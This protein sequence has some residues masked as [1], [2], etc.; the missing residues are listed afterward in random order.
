MSE[1]ERFARH[2]AL[3]EV[4]AGGQARLEASRMLI[5]GLGGLGC[6]AAQYLASSGVGTLMLN[7]FDH[8][9]SS[10]LPRQILFAEADIGRPK[11][12]AAAAA[13]QRLNAEARIEALPARLP[14]EGLFN[15]ASRAD[16]VLDCTDNFTTRLAINRACVTAGKPLV[17]GA[18][19]RFEGQI[20]VFENGGGGPCYRCLYSEED[21]LLGDCAGNGVLAPVPGVIGSLMALEA[22]QMTIAGHSPLNGRLTLWDAL[23]GTWQSIALARD[24]ACPVCG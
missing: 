7:D 4:G 14:D 16:V 1:A 9:D 24:P 3:R 17:S 2:V 19:L 18:A 13:L 15:A 8:V 5:V 10:N 22:M 12:E 21:E 11:V 23:S 20:V 6:P